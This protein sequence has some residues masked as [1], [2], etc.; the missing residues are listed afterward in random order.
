MSIVLHIFQNIA[1]VTIFSVEVLQQLLGH[2]S[3]QAW[4][5]GVDKTELLRTGRQLGSLVVR[6]WQPELCF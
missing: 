3:S 1:G 6:S 5:E 4:E 2:F